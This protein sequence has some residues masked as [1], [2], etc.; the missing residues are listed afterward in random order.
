MPNKSETYTTPT[1]FIKFPKTKIG[2]KEESVIKK[3]DV[4]E[5]VDAS[6]KFNLVLD[7]KDPHTQEILDVLREQADAIKGRNCEPYKKDMVIDEDTQE[8]KESGMITISFT[9][10]Y[11]PRMIDSKLKECNVVLGWGSR[12]KVKFSTKPFNFKG[13][14]GLS[15]YVVMIQVIE[16][17]S[18]GFDTSGFEAQEGFVAEENAAAVGWE[19]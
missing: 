13:K 15:K 9:S 17:K 11:A 14:V 8:K 12:V 2:D 19:E 10:A 6:W 5:N 7:P 3:Y 16:P 1:G 4:P 18:G